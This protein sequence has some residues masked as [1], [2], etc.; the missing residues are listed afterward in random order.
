V[1]IKSTQVGLIIKKL[2]ARDVTFGSSSF[3]IRR[4]KCRKFNLKIHSKRVEKFK[5][6]TRGGWRRLKT[7]LETSG[8]D[9][10]R[11]SFELFNS[12]NFFNANNWKFS[13]SK[14]DELSLFKT[15]PKTSEV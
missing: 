15:F 13:F 9:V 4:Q 11:G 5:K 2:P 6:Y 7:T 14:G 10:Y 12:I 1:K 8:E 3:T